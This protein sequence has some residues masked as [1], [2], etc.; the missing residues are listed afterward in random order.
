LLP[1]KLSTKRSCDLKLEE[2]ISRNLENWW[3]TYFRTCSQSKLNLI[4]VVSLGILKF[5]SRRPRYIISGTV[6]VLVFRGWIFW[7]CLSDLTLPLVKFLNPSLIIRVGPLPV[8][9]FAESWCWID[10]VS[11]WRQRGFV[12]YS[13]FVCK[14][15]VILRF[16][17]F[18]KIVCNCGVSYRNE[19]V[20]VLGLLNS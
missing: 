20:E 10:V 2:A 5:E 19:Y 8:E 4:L 11:T 12:G 14:F 9:F 6:W 13:L 3:K 7:L 15:H 16:M 17:Y 18:E 1:S